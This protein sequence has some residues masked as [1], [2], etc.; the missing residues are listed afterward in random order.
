[1]IDYIY[2]AIIIIFVVILLALSRME[3]DNELND[4][5]EEVE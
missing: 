3:E 5:K 2:I 4:E 1:M